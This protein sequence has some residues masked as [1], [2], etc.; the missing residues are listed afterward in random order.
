MIFQ[1]DDEDYGASGG[2]RY[3]VD[4]GSGGGGGGK[5]GRR[6]KYR[7]D[8][9]EGSGDSYPYYTGTRVTRKYSFF[10]PFLI[11]ESS[12]SNVVVT[13]HL[14]AKHALNS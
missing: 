13:V 12:I 1:M 14:C 3:Y 2:G 8:D 5:G 7:Y 9:Q 6:H 11:P 10:L 4:Y